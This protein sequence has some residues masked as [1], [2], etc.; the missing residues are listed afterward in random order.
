MMA[1]HDANRP[2]LTAEERHT[3]KALQ[4]QGDV[5]F[6]RTGAC[7]CGRPIPSSKTYCSWD[8]YQKEVENG[9]DDDSGEVD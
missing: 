2:Y 9:D 6:F 8:C 1:R 5:T 4:S 7:L 3:F